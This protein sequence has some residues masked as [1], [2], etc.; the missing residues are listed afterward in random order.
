MAILL[1]HVAVNIPTGAQEFGPA[2]V[3][4]NGEIFTL[5]MARCTTATPTFWPD[6]ATTINAN[7]WISFDGG[8]TW[9][10]ILI[11]FGSNGGIY[12]LRN[13]TQLAESVATGFAVRQGGRQIKAEIVVTNG[14]LVSEITM[15]VT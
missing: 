4:N 11:G 7:I 13:G 3:P 15:E 9:P 8:T 6:A 2:N 12:T 14:P 10:Y 1:N 5:R